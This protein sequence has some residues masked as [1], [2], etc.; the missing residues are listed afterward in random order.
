MTQKTNW[1]KSVALASRPIKIKN[2]RADR[3]A[4]FDFQSC[5]DPEQV[6]SEA[7]QVWDRREDATRQRDLAEETRLGEL[8]ETMH[9]RF[10]TLSIH[11]DLQRRDKECRRKFAAMTLDFNRNGRHLRIEHS[12][13]L[14]QYSSDI[15]REH[16]TTGIQTIDFHLTDSVGG[17]V[18]EARQ[19]ET[20]L[21]STS[22]VLRTFARGRVYSASAVLFALGGERHADPACEFLIHRS[23]NEL[24][25][26]TRGTLA[27]QAAADEWMASVISQA[28]G[29]AGED[30]QALLTRDFVFGAARSLAAN[31]A[32]CV[33]D[34]KE[35]AEQ[36]Y[37][38]LIDQ[39]REAEQIALDRHKEE[40]RRRAANFSNASARFG[41]V[42]RTPTNDWVKDAAGRLR[43]DGDLRQFGRQA[44]QPQAPSTTTASHPLA[45]LYAE[46]GDDYR[47]KHEAFLE[48]HGLGHLVV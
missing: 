7:I 38:R 18:A 4:E 29:L 34:E 32:T 45:T 33:R 22:A 28:T 3:A 26:Q 1:A 14:K 2:R 35:H 36:V 46:M 19:I 15:I 41:V 44:P 42:Q 47:V 17:L 6:R 16:L 20:V 9:R 10:D 13:D 23:S 27:E 25:E 48:S 8:L 11:N 21:K 39:K 43:F 30:V 24:T 12:G 5:I 31:F 40:S 37:Q